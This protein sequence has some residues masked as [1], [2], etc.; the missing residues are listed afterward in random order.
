MAIILEAAYSKKL[1]LPNYSSHSYVVSIR[2]ELADASQVES[3]SARLYAL[4]QQSVDKEIQQTGFVPPEGYGTTGTGPATNHTN[5]NQDGWQCSD[6]QRE[7]IA[8]IVRE[9]N[10]D[11]NEVEQLAVELHGHGVRSLN[12]LAASGFIDELLERYGGRKRNG[13]RNGNTRQP[14]NGNGGAR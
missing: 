2:T 1:G 13:H 8:R 3:E 4:L 7:F 11:K 12:R 14:V 5:G 9:N 6:K 10:L